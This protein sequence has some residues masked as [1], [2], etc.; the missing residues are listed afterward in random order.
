MILV[1]LA[2][3]EV[4]SEAGNEERQH[5]AHL[6]ARLAKH[7]RAVQGNEGVTNDARHLACV[8][9]ESCTGAKVRPRLCC[10]KSSVSV[11]DTVPTM[12]LTLHSKVVG[13]VYVASRL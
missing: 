5:H 13:I 2:E 1:L 3:L 9:Y 6:L 7:V 11:R 4:R 12:L 10:A 8:Q